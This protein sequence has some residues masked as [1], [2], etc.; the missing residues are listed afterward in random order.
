M[1]ASKLAVGSTPIVSGTVGRLLF[2]NTGDVLGQ[3]ANLFWDNTNERLGI[4]TSSPINTLHVV[5]GQLIKATADGFESIK[6]QNFANT[7]PNTISFY[8]SNGTTQTVVLGDN[9][10]SVAYPFITG[11]RADYGFVGNKNSGFH[12]FAGTNIAQTI[13]TTGNIGI[14]TTTDA[15]FRLDVNGSTRIKSDNASA[16]GS[17]LTVLNNSNTQLLVVRNDGSLHVGFTQDILSFYGAVN[18]NVIRGNQSIQYQSAGG[19]VSRNFHW[20]TNSNVFTATVED[21]PHVVMGASFAPTSGV[22]KYT[23]L[24]LNPNINQTGGANGITRGLVIDPTLTAAADFRAIETTRGN[25]ALCT[26]SGNVGI[27]TS[28]PAYPLHITRNSSSNYIQLSGNSNKGLF[29]EGSG[30]IAFDTSGN[31]NVYTGGVN[32]RATISS[33][34]NL[35]IN[36]TTDAG[37][38]LDVNGTA[39]VSGGFTIDSTTAPVFKGVNP[40]T[41]VTNSTSGGLLLTT[42][43]GSTAM[44]IA[45]TYGGAGSRLTLFN[46]YTD[47]PTSRIKINLGGVDTACF[48]ADGSLQIGNGETTIASAILSASSTT[49]GFLPPRMTNAQRAAIAS[50]AVGLIVYC[51]DSTE[52]LYVYKST[53][54][55]FMV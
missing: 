27:G 6:L 10:A 24:V 42:Q 16:S 31:F 34:G 20:F 23:Q 11:M 55:T 48:F 33:G 35:L 45:G 3:S 9:G 14:N 50:P 30:L 32:L 25:V 37:F 4:G 26:T 22:S 51:T 41:G 52:G 15:G 1:N 29:A 36:T 46:N 44:G 5:G 28:S 18:N 40:L 47:G 53:G 21:I 7:Y 17:A 54:W 19:T 39:R 43:T 8:K 13:H 12:I 2:Q 38:K 49:R